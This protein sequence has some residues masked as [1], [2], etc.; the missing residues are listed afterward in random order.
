MF[1]RFGSRREAASWVSGGIRVRCP[2]ASVWPCQVAW[3]P[4][5]PRLWAR[6][7][8]TCGRMRTLRLRL[9]CSRPASGHAVCGRAK[10]SRPANGG[11]LSRELG[12]PC[13]RECA[14]TRHGRR[15]SEVSAAGWIVIL[16]GHHCHYEGTSRRPG[17]EAT[18]PGG[19]CG[20]HGRSLPGGLRALQARLGWRCTRPAIREAGACTASHAHVVRQGAV[21][22]S[23]QGLAA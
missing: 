19:R 9:Q 15:V 3:P 4:A 6:L 18:L 12:R 1:V 2:P 16:A 8:T 17:G 11:R 14:E 20:G 10:A 7:V 13:A 23:N 5:G 22:P 21:A